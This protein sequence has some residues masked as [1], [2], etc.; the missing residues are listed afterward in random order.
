MN[1]KSKLKYF[2]TSMGICTFFL[3]GFVG[4]TIVEKN[5]SYLIS[6]KRLRFLSYNLKNNDL[7]FIKIHFMGKDFAFNFK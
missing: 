6:G 4:F 3:V 7:E 1:R 5:S 2:F